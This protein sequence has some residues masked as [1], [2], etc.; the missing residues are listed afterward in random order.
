MVQCPNCKLLN[1]RSAL[2]CD[3]GYDFQTGRV[4][5]RLQEHTSSMSRPTDLL[6]PI[7]IDA[8]TAQRVTKRAAVGAFLVGGMTTFLAVC[9]YFGMSHSFVTPQALVDGVLFIG[10]GV[11]I[12]KMS[13]AAAVFALLL[14]IVERIYVGMHHPSAWLTQGVWSV[15]FGLVFM[16]GVRGAFAYHG[17]Q[18]LKSGT[19]AQGWLWRLMWPR[20]VDVVTAKSAATRA[21]IVSYIIAG[22]TGLAAVLSLELD[23]SLR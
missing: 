16:N 13:R 14:W 12:K 10:I 7:I 22:I 5:H 4:Q 19:N 17:Y 15:I 2:I 1:P 9:V 23:Q 18:P 6:W 20:I 21:A 8:Q 11:C 3:C